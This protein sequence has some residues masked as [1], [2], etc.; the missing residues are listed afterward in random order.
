VPSIDI[1]D[2]WE[3][4]TRHM[5][6]EQPPATASY[7]IFKK[8][9]KTYAKNGETGHIEYEDTDS[10]TAINNALNSAGNKGGGTVFIRKG[11]YQIDS[12]IE[13]SHDAIRLVGENPKNTILAGTANL[14]DNPIINI[15]KST[16]DVEI[17]N[18]MLDGANMPTSPYTT[19]R[20]GIH[21][22][23]FQYRIKI[24]D[25]IVQN[26]PATGIGTD[27]IVRGWIY[28][29]YVYNCG[30]SG[31]SAGSNGI[32]IAVSTDVRY[33]IITNNIVDS[34]KN[35]GILLEYAGGEATK[36]SPY[37]IISNNIVKYCGT[38]ASQSAGIRLDGVEKTIVSG[39]TLFGNKLG[40]HI[41]KTE[42]V[43]SNNPSRKISVIGNVIAESGEHG[44]RIP[45]DSTE[46]HIIN[47]R[48][49]GSNYYGIYVNTDGAI[50]EHNIFA[51]NSSGAI[52][53]GSGKHPT[54]KRNTGYTTEASGTATIPSGQTSVTFA[55]GLAGT[56]TMVVLGATHSEVADA[57]WSADDTNITITVPSAVSADRQISWYAEYK[58]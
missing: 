7:I 22:T 52:L 45:Y 6:V 54:I 56:P 3:L 57:I 35:N 25:L 34:C 32:G 40:I 19:A 13:I 39:N 10:A 55:H 49:I 41:T 9:N 28:N 18:L 16:Y 5:P 4:V 26:T 44:I 29:N 50:I 20:K 17:A 33:I 1:Y 24:H 53:I 51:D 15:T 46:I 27:S 21:A 47:N 48:I 36:F 37:H 58:P 30:T 38:V 42:W 31:E 12:S 11:T 14:G 23:G 43:T 2:S 8:G